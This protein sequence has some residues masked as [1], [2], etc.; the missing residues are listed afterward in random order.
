MIGKLLALPVTLPLNMAVTAFVVGAIIVATAKDAL[1]ATVK[2][3]VIGVPAEIGVVAATIC[4]A[5][6]R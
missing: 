1:D 3:V 5:L 6:R 4:H 2:A